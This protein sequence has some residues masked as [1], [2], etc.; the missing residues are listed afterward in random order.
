MHDPTTG[1]RGCSSGEGGYRNIFGNKYGQRL[2]AIQ[3]KRER[4]MQQR[5][6][7]RAAAATAAAAAAADAGED[8]AAE[9]ESKADGARGRPTKRPS[10]DGEEPSA[11]GDVVWDLGASDDDDADSPGEGEEE[12]ERRKAKRRRQ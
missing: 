7:E 2:A 10:P 9:A 6:E 12:E 4:V 8:E 5:E 11:A 3:I 1:C